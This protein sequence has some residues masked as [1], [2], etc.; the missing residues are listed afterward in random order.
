MTSI[1]TLSFT[2]RFS[3]SS[4]TLGLDKQKNISFLPEPKEGLC[5]SS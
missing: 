3:A 5:R 4:E 2:K 1:G